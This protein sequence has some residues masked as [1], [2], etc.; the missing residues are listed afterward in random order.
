LFHYVLI[1]D[2]VSVAFCFE[3]A[4]NKRAQLTTRSSKSIWVKVM[5]IDTAPVD[6]SVPVQNTG[7]SK[8]GSRAWIN[9]L[10]LEIFIGMSSLFMT[11]QIFEM[12]AG[13]RLP[14]L[15]AIMAVLAAFGGGF[16]AF[17]CGLDW[18]KKN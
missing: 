11:A 17:R 12:I 7:K 6:S 1:P 13:D 18:R 2:K 3:V 5:P 8:A 16:S 14:I 9:L 10:P 4:F 15:K